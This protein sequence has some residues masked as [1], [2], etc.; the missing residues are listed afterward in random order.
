[1]NDDS[2][3]TSV[4]KSHNFDVEARVAVAVHPQFHVETRKHS[5]GSWE[6]AAQQSQG[7]A[8]T[9]FLGLLG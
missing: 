3:Y 8:C 5:L 2:T 4:S 7:S 6:V 1:M 9:Y